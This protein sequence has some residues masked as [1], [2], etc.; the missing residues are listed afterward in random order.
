MNAP[1]SRVG[2]GEVRHARHEPRTHAFAY[3]VF[4]PLLDLSE[5]DRV[6]RGRWLWSVNRRN[7]A[8][9]HRA[10]YLGD[11][12]CALAD[13]A[14]ERVEA[15]LGPQERGRVLLL[16]NLR[17]FGYC[18]NPI[19]MYFCLNPAGEPV[20]ML[21]DVT[22]T[23]WG[24]SDCYV[25]PMTVDGEVRN[26]LSDKILHVSPFMGM[27][28]QYRW[29]I[30]LTGTEL[31]VG[32]ASSESGGRKFDASL[33]LALRPLDGKSLAVALARHPFMTGRVV[34]GIY[35]QALRLKLKG[36]AYVPHPREISAKQQ[37]AE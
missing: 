26:H 28:Q 3:P 25:V 6:F 2:F 27:E 13:T 22:N 30:R 29:N 8:A 7:L 32:I 15:S 19:A 1:G 37:G 36:L 31:F 35:W 21:A 17:Y 20:A 24:E 4:M 23:P 33:R 9:F 5:L 12:Q 11:P 34:L 10:D 14:W 16:A 18:I